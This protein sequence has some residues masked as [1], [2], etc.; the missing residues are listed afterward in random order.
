MTAHHANIPNCDIDF[1]SDEVILNPWPHYA[2]M[3]EL[4]PV[5]WMAQHGNYALTRHAEVRAGL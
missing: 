5:I 4:G 2:G 1:W 3:R